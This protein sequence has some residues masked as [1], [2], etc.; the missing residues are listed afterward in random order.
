MKWITKEGKKMRVED[1]GDNH[2]LNSHRMLRKQEVEFQECEMMYLHP[3]WGPRGDMAQLAAEQ[4]MDR[5]FEVSMIRTHYIRKM[6]SIIK[7][8]GLTPKPVNPPKKPPKIKSV[9]HLENATICE[10]E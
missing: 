3:F 10:L 9:E 1:M 2:L 6:D 5:E 7:E 8:R 4:D